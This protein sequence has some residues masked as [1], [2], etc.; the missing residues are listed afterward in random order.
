M[1]TE[2]TLRPSDSLHNVRYEI[3]GKLGPDR[4]HAAGDV[5]ARAVNDR[6]HRPGRAG[7]ERRGSDELVTPAHG[8][9][10]TEARGETRVRELHGRRGACSELRIVAEDHHRRRQRSVGINGCCRGRHA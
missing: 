10:G 6:P 5:G 8:D 3:R 2:P 9:G 7:L 4:E 1:P